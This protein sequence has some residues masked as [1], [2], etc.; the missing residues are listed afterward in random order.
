[1][2]LAMGFGNEGGWLASLLA[3]KN[4]DIDSVLDVLQPV[5]SRRLADQSSRN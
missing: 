4:G 3:A 5:Q 1:M 2:M